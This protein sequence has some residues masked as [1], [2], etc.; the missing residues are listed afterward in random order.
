ML[1]YKILLPAEWAQFEAAGRFDGSPLD[2]RDGYV[3]LSSRDQIAGTA[4]RF[5]ADAPDLVVAAV[6]AQLLGAWLRWEVSANGGPYPHLY[7][8]LPRVAVVAVHR[9]AG[10]ESVD[11]VVPRT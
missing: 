2:L 5:F 11:D 3:H 6:D 9:V 10:T 1:I 7:A 8:P 4:R